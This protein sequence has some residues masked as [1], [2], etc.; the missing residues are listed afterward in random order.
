MAVSRVDL[1]RGMDVHP[2]P[3]EPRLP[4]VKHRQEQGRIV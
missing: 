3:Y 4:S 2:S 1:H